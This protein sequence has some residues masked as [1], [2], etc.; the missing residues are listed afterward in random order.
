[1]R[2]A[3]GLLGWLPG[4]AL[5]ALGVRALAAHQMLPPGRP[6][7]GAPWLLLIAGGVSVLVAC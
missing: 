6:P 3:G 2:P 5:G 4:A 7:G 1:M